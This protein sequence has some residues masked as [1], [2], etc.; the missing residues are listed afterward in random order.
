M[1]IGE[2]W[3]HG[4]VRAYFELSYRL[5]TG[6]LEGRRFMELSAPLAGVEVHGYLT[7]HDLEAIVRSLAPDPSSRLLDLGC[8]VG[9]VATEIAWR[10]GSSVVGID[11]SRH[12][13]AAAAGRAV[14]LGLTGRVRFARGSIRRPPRVGATG[15]YA[16]DSLMFVALDEEVLLGIRDALADDGRLLTTILASGRQPID[17]VRAIAERLGMTIVASDDVTPAL[18]DS[19]AHRQRVARRLLRVRGGSIRGRLAMLG[20]VVE[21]AGTQRLIRGG[22]LRRWRT[23]VDTRRPVR[24]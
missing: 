21:E 1:S 5:L 16:L 17:P 7:E 12:A 10:T 24:G 3:L 23:I 15:G 9:G 18:H 6:T 19:S 8:G 2:R 13:V 4:A 22:R 11:I 20:V 14:R